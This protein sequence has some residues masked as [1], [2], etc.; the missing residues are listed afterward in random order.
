MAEA[1]QEVE[2]Q[3]SGKLLEVEGQR[4]AELRSNQEVSRQTS[5]LR[6][7]TVKGPEEMKAWSRGFARPRGKP[8]SLPAEA[9]LPGPHLSF[10]A[11]QLELLHAGAA[12]VPPDPSSQRFQTYD[13]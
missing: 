7:R 13:G 11:S 6:K 10:G 5:I 3:G 4:I 8:S 1:C 12:K 2:G 9:R